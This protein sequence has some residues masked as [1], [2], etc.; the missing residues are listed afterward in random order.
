MDAGK[1][2]AM[3]KFSR[4]EALHVVKTAAS[5]KKQ[6]RFDDAA[7][8]LLNLLPPEKRA[9][10]LT[11]AGL[12]KQGIFGLSAAAS[13]ALYSAIAAA[14]ASGA[15]Y[16]HEGG[17][18]EEARKKVAEQAATEL[19]QMK[20]L[21]QEAAGEM[22]KRLSQF[23]TVSRGM[24]SP[25]APTAMAAAPQPISLQQQIINYVKSQREGDIAEAFGAMR[26]QPQ[27]K[28]PEFMAGQELSP[29]FRGFMG[30]LE[31]R[32]PPS[33][34]MP[35]I[36]PPPATISPTP[37]AMPKVSSASSMKKEAALDKLIAAVFPL[38]MKGVK[39]GGGYLLQK[40]LKQGTRQA[41]GH[42]LRQGTRYLGRP[43]GYA[44][45]GA[46][47]LFGKL[48]EKMPRESWRHAGTG[49]AAR[50][51]RLMSDPRLAGHVG[52]KMMRGT[53]RGLGRFA[54]GAVSMAGLHGLGQ[55]GAAYLRGGEDTG[56]E[57]INP[58]Y[59][60][61]SPTQLGEAGELLN[62]IERVRNP[63]GEV[64]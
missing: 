41:A 64:Q 17:K 24:G 2:D 13:Y 53:G 63:E 27:W 9:E 14:M 23:D 8:R 46:K 62:W 30:A 12:E 16:W 37:G 35:G 54:T 49:M 38:I 52:S 22:H 4:D 6:A 34:K 31:Q 21:R 32:K 25:K 39:R 5:V 59:A 58:Y 15:F 50:G 29:R 28:P 51:A 40:G 18:N 3:L 36:A 56:P 1:A 57:G 10:V 26:P 44:S 61:L 47:R 20:K 55:E 48:L 45:G 33:V 11:K 43:L 19:A 7:R 60:G 42:G